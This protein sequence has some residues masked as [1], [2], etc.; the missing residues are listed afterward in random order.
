MTDTIDPARRSINM[1]KIRSK[2]TS[3]ERKVRSLLHWNGYRY[4]VNY[5]SLPGK[6]DI[7]FPKRKR[8][9]FIHGC[10]WHNH[11]KNN[12]RYNHTPASN[13][14]Y[15]SGKI[16]RNMERDASHLKALRKLGYRV[17]ILWECEVKK[18]R[19]ETKLWN[20]LRY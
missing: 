13:V 7:V 14:E 8:A 4:R 11:K 3:P 9:I 10:F 5:P 16:L 12:C 6:P 1:S 18:D 19:F 17:L 20:F 15:W 2:D